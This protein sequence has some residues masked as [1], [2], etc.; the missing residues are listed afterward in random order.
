MKKVIIESNRGEFYLTLTEEQVAFAKWL[1]DRDIISNY[2]ILEE[3][4]WEEIK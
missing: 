3:E 1:F 4:S 2:T